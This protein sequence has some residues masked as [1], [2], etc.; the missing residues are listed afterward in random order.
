MI[1][2]ILHCGFLLLACSGFNHSS[3]S[4]VLYITF[5]SIHY[6]NMV[7]GSC[8]MNF[9]SYHMSFFVE[10]RNKTLFYSIPF[11]MLNNK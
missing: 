8:W 11:W 2:D 1:R 3:Y 7:V 10:I 6:H 4:I 9:E 5:A